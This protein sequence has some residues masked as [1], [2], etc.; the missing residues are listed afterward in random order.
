MY[1]S[2]DVVFNESSFPFAYIFSKSGSFVSQS[3]NVSS[4]AIIPLLPTSS[5]SLTSSTSVVSDQSDDIINPASIVEP[6]CTNEVPAEN[7]SLN[8]S[9]PI[10]T[11]CS[12]SHLMQTRSKNRIFKPK[13]FIATKEPLL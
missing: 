1:I 5:F 7:S 6:A 12:R 11:P 4:S 2:R 8:V 10:P 13:V 9:T 3:Y